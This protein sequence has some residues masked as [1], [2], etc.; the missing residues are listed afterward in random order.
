MI[1][2]WE[3][4]ILLCEEIKL[5]LLEYEGKKIFSK[6]GISIPKGY[7][8]SNSSEVKPINEPVIVKAQL[9]LGGR[10]KRDL[11]KQA[12]TVLE[13]RQ[14]SKK[15]LGKIVNN[16]KVQKILIE[17]RLDIAKEF[18]VG[19]FLER[20]QQVP[21]IIVSSCGGV[22]IESVEKKEIFSVAIDPLIGLQSFMI[23]NLV[24]KL[25][26]ENDLKKEM[27]ELIFNLYKIFVEC[28]AEL[29][30][31]NPL[32][33][34]ERK[35]LIAADSKIIIDDSAL[36]RQPQFQK[37][38]KGRDLT[39]FEQNILKLGAS[40]VEIPGGNIGVVTSGA[41]LQMATVDL[42][43]HY[44]GKVAAAVDIAEIAFDSTHERM[45]KMLSLLKKLKLK[46]ILLSFFLQIGRCDIF[47]KSISDV[48]SD[49]S[50]DTSVIIRLKGNKDDLAKTI[51]SSRNFFV[52]ECFEESIKK[53]V[54]KSKQDKE[55][56]NLL[57]L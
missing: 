50:D 42:I 6:Y 28:D 16:L 18:Y 54:E 12:R 39:M 33:I 13:L 51:L 32:V 20:D 2:F 36:Y 5:K 45:I 49:I 24:R 10:G 15:L 21:L 34:T 4:I 25:N 3:I 47:A 19:V 43:E 55:R 53:I 22:D 35:R 26:L 57:C 7:V 52:T 17:E 38:G 44:G 27:I 11:I 23:R 37:L 1:S 30:E 48:F 56:K 14:I 31:I 46:A 40:G 41:G 9:L 29:V 8:I